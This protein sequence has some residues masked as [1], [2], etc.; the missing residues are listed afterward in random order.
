MTKQKQLFRNVGNGNITITYVFRPFTQYFVDAPLVAITPQVLGYK[1]DTPVFGEFLTFFSADPLNLCQ[2]GRGAS[3]HSYFQFSPEMFDRVQVQA[4]AGPLKDIQRRSQSGFHQ[5]S[6]C[7]L[8]RSSSL[9]PDLSPSPCCWKT[10]PQHY[11]AT[12]M[13]DPR[14]GARFPSDVMLGIQA[15]ELLV[16]SD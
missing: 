6:L 10:S 7:T 13:L 14:D 9:D 5:G 1:L 4:L 16:S 11:A 8:P 2:V 12:T 3:L 15:K